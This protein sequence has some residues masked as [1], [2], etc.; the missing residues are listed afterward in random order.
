[1]T[2]EMLFAEMRRAAKE[3][4]QTYFAPLIGAVKGIQQQYRLLDRKR[5][6]DARSKG[7]GQ[8]GK[9]KSPN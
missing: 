4:P 3:V 7:R 8:A 1:M 5:A 9:V 2:K 6:R